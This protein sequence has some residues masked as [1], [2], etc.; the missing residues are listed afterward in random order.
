MELTYKILLFFNITLFII[1]QMDAIRTKE[2]KMIKFFQKTDD[3]IA[4]K[5]FIWLHIFLF[6]AIFML[7][8]T[9]FN[10]LLWLMTAFGIIHKLLHILFKN[11]PNNNVK[12]TFSTIIIDGIFITSIITLIVK[13]LEEIYV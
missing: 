11:H 9:S 12:E 6:A 7:L 3:K 10:L 8:E 13:L 4:E 5:I 2:W 1:H